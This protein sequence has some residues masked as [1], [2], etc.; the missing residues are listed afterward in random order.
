MKK[1]GDEELAVVKKEKD[2]DDETAILN[3][4]TFDEGKKDS[5]GVRRTW[6]R[7]VEGGKWSL[8]VRRSLRGRKSPVRLSLARCSVSRGMHKASHRYISYF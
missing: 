7:C 2:G 5:G 4:R 6:S 1:E 8:E 3:F